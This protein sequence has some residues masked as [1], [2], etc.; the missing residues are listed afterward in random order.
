MKSK[1]YDKGNKGFE[2]ELQI[3]VILC[4]TPLPDSMS[5]CGKKKCCN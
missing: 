4:F 3:Y 1:S 5:L 2:A